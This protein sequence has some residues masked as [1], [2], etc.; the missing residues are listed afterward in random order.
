MSDSS[1]RRHTSKDVKARLPRRRAFLFQFDTIPRFPDPRRSLARVVPAAAAGKSVVPR[2][3]TLGRCFSDGNI[4]VPRRHAAGCHADQAAPGTRDRRFEARGGHDG[5]RFVEATCVS[6]GPFV[7]SAGSEAAAARLGRLGFVTKP[8]SSAEEV[9]VGLWVRVPNLPTP[10]DAANA[11][12][13]LQRAGFTDA[14]IVN[15]G[16]PGNTVSLGVFGDRGKENG[17][18]Q[19]CAR[20]GLRRK[21]AIDCGRWTSIGS[22]SIARRMAACPRSKRSGQA[23]G[24]PAPRAEGLSEHHRYGCRTVSRDGVQPAA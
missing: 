16:S 9:R 2:L 13:A 8:R 11:L 5:R 10:D 4:V 12:A 17:S 18:P 6:V 23:R 7:D 22:I 14:Y 20:P 1:C 19:P 24:Q 15:D 3:D 21:P